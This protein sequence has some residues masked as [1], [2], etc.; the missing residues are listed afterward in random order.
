MA[1]SCINRIPR[2]LQISAAP[3]FSKGPAI[4][5]ASVPLVQKGA[6]GVLDTKRLKVSGM[7]ISPHSVLLGLPYIDGIVFGG[8]YKLAYNIL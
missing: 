4:V 8:T 6:T 5:R 3:L 1:T 7:E 2:L